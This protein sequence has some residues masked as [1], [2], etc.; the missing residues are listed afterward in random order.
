MKPLMLTRLVLVIIIFIAFFLP[1]IS[2]ESQAI[3]QISK[4]LTGKEQAKIDGISG[5]DV[6]VMANSEESRFMI[7]VIKIFKP[8]ITNADKKSYL[9]WIVPLLA[10]VLFFISNI[11]KNNKW[12]RLAAGVL[13]LGIFIV[14]VF[15]IMTIDLDKLVLNVR[16]AYGLWLAL[17]GYL[18][19]GLAELYSFISASR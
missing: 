13:C 19:F 16:I 2:V 7:S 6:P 9:I 8:D 5:F 14:A 18:G 11:L 3:G 1:W 10:V 12:A 4:L 15:K 17:L